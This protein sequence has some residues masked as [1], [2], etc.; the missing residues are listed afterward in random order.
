MK[1]HTCNSTPTP[2]PR[3]AKNTGHLVRLGLSPEEVLDAWQESADAG[4]GT[5]LVAEFIQGELELVVGGL[6]DPHFGPAVTL[7]LGGVAAEVLNDTV[8]VLAPPE[9]GEVES[10]AKAL[11]GASLLH[12]HRGVEPVDLP[13]LDAIIRTVADVL[14]KQ[15]DIIEIDCNPVVVTRGKPVVVD[16]LVVVRGQPTG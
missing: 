14:R 5:V 11:R 12:G 1:P 13:A 7:G 3:P 4:D 2:P 10:A 15:D 6:R 9:P 16:A 8:T